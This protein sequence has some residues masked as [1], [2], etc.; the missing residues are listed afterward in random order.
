MFANLLTLQMILDRTAT[1]VTTMVLAVG[2]E[3][4]ENK[5]EEQPYY[6]LFEKS[7]VR[8]IEVS[9]VAPL[10]LKYFGAKLLPV[11]ISDWG[12]SVEVT[13]YGLNSKTF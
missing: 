4:R 8:K 9:M 2:I 7:L 5:T 3:H 6:Q 1:G 11:R 10:Q 12:V 13:I